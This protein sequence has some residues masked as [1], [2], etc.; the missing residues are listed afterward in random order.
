[1]RSIRYG[2][3]TQEK[4][5][6]VKGAGNHYTAPYWEY[7]PRAVHR[8]NMDPVIA[9]WESPYAINRGNPIALNDPNGDCSNCSKEADDLNDRTGQ[10]DV[11]AG[12]KWQDSKGANYTYEDGIGWVQSEADVYPNYEAQSNFMSGNIKGAGPL[13]RQW[14]RFEISMDD[15]LATGFWETH[16]KSEFSGS[17]G[18]GDVAGARLQFK[19][20]QDVLDKLQT[21]SLEEA[22]NYGSATVETHWGG[23][24]FAQWGIFKGF[25]E[26]GE[27]V[28]E[29]KTRGLGFNIGYA[30]PQ[31]TEDLK[32][33][34]QIKM[35][36]E[37]TLRR[38][39]I[40]YNAVKG[41]TSEYGKIIRQ[42]ENQ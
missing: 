14:S 3:N 11:Q 38:A 12:E 2:F 39:I 8:W 34:T 5:D 29:A 16:L 25:S 23:F 41:D 20:N 35:T 32:W 9:P 13:V 42:Y 26:T 31:T 7:D 10:G 36:R 19:F 4:V 18:F 1:M 6:E 24:S 33:N 15:D 37:D 30:P 21:N 40:N 22:L 28:W 17:W 27:L